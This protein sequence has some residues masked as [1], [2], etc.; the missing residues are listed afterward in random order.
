MGVVVTSVFVATAARAQMQV[1]QRAQA[2]LSGTIDNALAW[3]SA[4][5]VGSRDQRALINSGLGSSHIKFRGREDL[6]GGLSASYWLEMGINTDSGTGTASNANNQVSGGSP[7]GALTFGRSSWVDVGGDWGR[8]RLGRDYTTTFWGMGTYVPLGPN[9][10]GSPLVLSGIGVQ[11][12]AA[13]GPFPA[14]NSVTFPGAYVMTRVRASNALAYIS[15]EIGG[16]TGWLQHYLGENGG[17]AAAG[18]NAPGTGRDDGNG[19]AARIGYKSGPLDVGV[20]YQKT[21][22]ALLGD[23]T[24]WNVGGQY[25]F[26]AWRAYALVNQDRS[27]A[28]PLVGGAPNATKA[29]SWSLGVTI[30][31]FQTDLVRLGVSRYSLDLGP[32]ANPTSQK[33]AVSYVK[34]LSKRTAIYTTFA[35]VD[36]SH[37]ANTVLNGAQLGPGVS[38]QTSR[39]FEVGVRHNF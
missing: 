21:T 20:A 10:I 7:P 32:G 3:G 2:E 6:G 35:Q 28:T 29:N 38:D 24:T 22:Y 8:V 1:P 9:G 15:P 31:V 18:A 36:N 12:P 23:Y 25:D 26:G 16:F 39:G 27:S 34:N 5:G 17:S 19:T 11:R 4:G 30:P 13:F 14:G 37:G 33:Y